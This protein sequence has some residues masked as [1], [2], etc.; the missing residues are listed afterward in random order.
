MDRRWFNEIIERLGGGEFDGLE[1]A[2]V[3]DLMFHL[4][5]PAKSPIVLNSSVD[6]GLIAGARLYRDSVAFLE[7]IAEHQP[8]KL[9]AKGNLALTMCEVI[10]ERAFTEEHE[11]LFGGRPVR[12]EL[13]LPYLHFVNVITGLAGLT[14]KQ[15]GKLAITKA[16][17][18][19]LK[20]GSAFKIYSRLF[21]ACLKKLSWAY[22]DWHPDC[23]LI[24]DLAGYSIYLVHKY[25]AETRPT[26]F[27]ADAFLKA[28]PHAA[29]AFPTGMR[30]SSEDWFRHAYSLRT[31]QRFLCRLGLVDMERDHEWN[32]TMETV[33]RTRLFDELIVFRRGS[34]AGGRRVGA[35]GSTRKGRNHVLQFKI[36]LKGSRPPI[37]RRIQVPA[38]YTF[39][40]L[41][42]AIQDAMGWH[43]CHL[44]EFTVHD[45]STGV[46][47]QIGIA[48][49]ELTSGEEILAG[50]KH[51]IADWFTPENT[52]AA[53]DY[54]F[55]DGWE[56]QVKFE[57]SP[58]RDKDRTYPVCLDGQR[59][60]PPE[61]VGG[62]DGYADFLKAISDPGHEEHAEWL[63]WV[64]GEFDPERFRPEEVEFDDP[65]DRRQI[66][67]L[68][69]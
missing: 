14:R 32:P 40:E 26:R 27:Y 53:Y 20:K 52:I 21:A 23:R 13:D 42:V 68:D 9:T 57:G 12:S 61:D 7:A 17:Q 4:S 50:W 66:M 33:R 47:A 60:C 37:W 1:P 55:G 6:K 54:D 59:A 8:V 62:I 30:K 35:A 43:D 58:V 31:F 49:E 39:W 28:L 2:D 29:E 41:H 44:H 15:H 64:G 36:T 18:S 63:E 48:D 38:G 46:G 25:G 5:D 19:D 34:A 56:H 11:R 65:E 10:R 67:L 3:F 24:Q 51:K 69:S 22:A 16:C 45:P